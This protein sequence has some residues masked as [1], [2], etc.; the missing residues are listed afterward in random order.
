MSPVT[1]S[2]LQHFRF[3]TCQSQIL[4]SLTNRNPSSYI[5]ARTDQT[6]IHNTYTSHKCTCTLLHKL[7]HVESY[8]VS[9][10][11]AAVQSGIILVPSHTTLNPRQIYLLYQQKSTNEFTVNKLTVIFIYCSPPHTGNSLVLADRSP[12]DC[13]G[14]T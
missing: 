6:Y 11:S 10:L 13:V 1:C 3:F 9:Y 12:Q 4:L 2:V 14:D 8:Q 7:V 5:N